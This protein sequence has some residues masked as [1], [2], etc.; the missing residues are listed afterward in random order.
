[1]KIVLIIS[2]AVFLIMVVLFARL[3]KRMGDPV[4]KEL[5]DSYYYH[6]WKSKIIYSPMGNWFELGYTE[7][8]AN[9]ETFTVLSREFGK[10][11]D[12]IFWKGKAQQVDHA[13]F[14][15]DENNIPK[16]AQRVYYNLRYSPG[17]TVIDGA[18]PK[19]Y[20]PYKLES[21]TYNQGWARDAESV[22]LYGK[23]VNVHGKTFA[24][25]NQTL[26]YDSSYL[27]AIVEDYTSETGT[28][29]DN[30]KVVKKIDKPVGTFEA[31]N[32][33]YARIGNTILLSNWKNDF[34]FLPFKSI[35]TVKI[36]DERNIAV[37]GIFVSDGKQMEDI[38]LASIE[39]IDR[40]FMKDKNSVYYDTQK[41]EEADPASF[42]PVSEF[43]SKDKQR[44]FY[45]TQ[46]LP[47]AN[48]DK[49]S[50]NYN[51]D[52][53]SDGTYSFKNGQLIDST[54]K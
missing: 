1:M 26:A 45:K 48:P 25:I 9:P 37:N 12:S 51:T 44:V 16:D 30:T 33:F 49:F 2:G 34:S 6:R 23:K 38:D 13:S 35:D 11:K 39:I 20:K 52:T 47:N 14:T 41:I 42:T 22:F 40:D 27:Y 8:E 24:R 7:M 50:I 17:L 10:D 4:N 21:L 5:S 18:D 54:K 15:I 53:G 32:D 28:S 46:A 3:F 36:I 29:E 43:Y 31:I 19:T